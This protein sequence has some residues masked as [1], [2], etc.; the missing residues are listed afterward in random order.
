VEIHKAYKFRLTPTPQ[1]RILLAQAVGSCRFVYNHLLALNKERY[2]VEQK[3]IFTTEMVN[4]LPH[5]KQEYPFLSDVFSQ[6]LQQSLRHLGDAF[7]NFFKGNA[8]FP[9]FQK[10][11]RADSFTCP[12]KFRVVEETNRLFVPKI[13][14]VK[15]RNS[16][17][18][19]KGGKPTRIMGTI[20][21]M[22]VSKHSGK[23]YVSI[24]TEQFLFDQVNHHDKPLGI[25]VGLKVFASLS[26]GEEIENPR[27]YRKWEEKLALEQRRL[28]RKV[29]FSNNWVKQFYEVQR[30][31]SI[32]ANSR[33]DFLNKTSS[34][35]VNN[36]NLFGLEDLAVANLVKNH[37]LAKSISDVG[38]G[39]FRSMMEYKA[40]RQSKTVVVVDRFYPS[41]Q[42]CSSCRSRKI[43]PLHLRTYVCEDCGTTIDRDYNASLNLERE[44]IRIAAAI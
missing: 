43:M 16:L 35:L 1:Q 20:K 38:W 41:S 7:Q 10:K 39:K 36:H 4:M 25:D 12:Q 13:G 40:D 14:E 15:Y 8:E 19:N 9:T 21:T 37:K 29:K 5:L 18:K 31:H 24:L 42:I 33:L 28:S 6:S 26:N 17:K 11:G 23:W 30:I 22:T 2:D 32:I 3:F 27:F 34:Q 44:V